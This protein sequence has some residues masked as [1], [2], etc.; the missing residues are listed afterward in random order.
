[1]KPF[2]YFAETDELVDTICMSLRAES[3][4]S[5]LGSPTKRGNLEKSVSSKQNYD[6]CHTFAP[7][8]YQVMSYNPS[9]FPI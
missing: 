6:W 5:G 1:M 2:I 3:L 7:D 9:F 4:L 8:I